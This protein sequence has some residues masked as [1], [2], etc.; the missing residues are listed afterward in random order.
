MAMTRQQL[1][2]LRLSPRAAL[3][4]LCVVSGGVSVQDLQVKEG[5][6]VSTRVKSVEHRLQFGPNG[7]SVSDLGSA[8]AFENGAYQVSYVEL[9]ALQRSRTGD[10]VMLCL[11]RIPRGC[12]AGDVR[13]RI[14]KA[15][16]LRTLDSWTMPDS[17]RSCGGA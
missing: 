14:H 6:C 5:T 3:I 7:L 17:E 8:V 13:G 9:P 11:I 16:N 4:G 1:A 12:P 15:T 10:P 2:K